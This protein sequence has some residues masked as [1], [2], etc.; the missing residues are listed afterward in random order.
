MQLSRKAVALLAIVPLLAA[1]SACDKV[2]KEDNAPLASPR[3]CVKA[4]TPASSAQ[5]PEVKPA[6]NAPVPDVT[7]GTEFGQEPTI[8]AGQG[9][10]SNDFIRNVL[11]K[12]SGSEVSPGADVVV[13][14]KGQKW[15]GEVFDSSWK[16]GKTATF[17]LRNVIQ[18]W[19]WGLAG[20]HVGDRVELVVP[21]KLGYDEL[22]AEEQAQKAAGQE[23]P[24][25]NALAG[26]TL[27]FVVD[28]VF[29]PPMLNESQ[30]A[31]YTQVLSKSKP[32]DAK[33]P[34][35]LRL[36]CKPGE[37][38]QPAYVE[39]AKVPS[40]PEVVWTTAGQGRVIEAGDQVGYVIVYGSWGDAPQS[41]WTNG[42]SV[43]WATAEDV[44]AVGKTVG[45]RVVLVGPPNEHAKR[46]I[47]QIVDI[48]DAV[49]LSDKGA[50]TAQS[51]AK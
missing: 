39:G 12:G 21:P 48:V 41:T 11:I 28:I 44:Q 29:S 32:T 6:E 7:E 25:K 22:T 24:G 18:G 31:A 15:N 19:R 34:E 17:N 5:V 2:E 10:P 49:S 13:N 45:S 3:A 38:P 14:Y 26:E 33:L 20:A 27:V 40:K 36:Y 51:P 50:A 47:V 37:E 35:G 43:T 8:S 46:G 30:L 9:E 23:I 16:R 4:I 42:S 1:L